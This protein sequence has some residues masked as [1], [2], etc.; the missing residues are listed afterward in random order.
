M[1]GG[2]PP[3]IR[4]LI[5][6]L[7]RLIPFQPDVN[8]RVGNKLFPVEPGAE[9]P[10]FIGYGDVLEKTIMYHTPPFTPAAAQTP[11]C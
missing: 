6:S 3:E 8:L 1:A 9:K 5:V 2:P 10:L 4:V 11:F 7:L